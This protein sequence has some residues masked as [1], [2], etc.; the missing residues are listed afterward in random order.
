MG[1]LEP[2]I[3]KRRKSARV[4]DRK[5]MNAIFYVLRD[6]M[7]WRDVP[8]RYGSYTTAYNRFNR[9]SRRGIW[10]QI[11]DQVAARSRVGLYFIDSTIVKAHR[12]ASGGKGGEKS[13]NRH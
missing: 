6:G 9:W 1:T 7:P 8:E 11:F 10:R 3:P 2:L 4:D 5:I 12:C 13:G